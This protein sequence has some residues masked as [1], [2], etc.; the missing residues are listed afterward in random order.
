MTYNK[1]KLENT[2]GEGEGRE[3]SCF[4]DYLTYMLVVNWRG[5]SV[6]NL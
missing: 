3:E 6:M 5:W 2:G 1:D 4:Y